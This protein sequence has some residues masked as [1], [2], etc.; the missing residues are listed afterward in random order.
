MSY[1]SYK[2]GVEDRRELL[3]TRLEQANQLRRDAHL[4]TRDIDHEVNFQKPLL[5][6]V[7]WNE[8][9]LERKA[10]ARFRRQQLAQFDIPK[11][12]NATHWQEERARVLRQAMIKHQIQMAWDSLTGMR[13]SRSPTGRPSRGVLKA[14]PSSHTVV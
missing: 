14:L 2:A 6:E 12:T 10:F 5:T 9:R 4:P 1:K 7:A 8:A 3:R 13:S 11:P